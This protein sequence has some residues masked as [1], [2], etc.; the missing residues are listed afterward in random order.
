[1]VLAD[2]SHNEKYKHLMREYDYTVYYERFYS[3]FFWPR[4][5]KL[6]RHTL[7]IARAENVESLWAGEPLPK[8]VVALIVGRL[9]GIPYF[10][11]THGADVLNPIRRGGIVGEWKKT[12]LTSVLRGAMFVTVNSEYTKSI[13]KKYGIDED[14]IH[15]IYPAPQN[16]PPAPAQV[17]DTVVQKIASLKQKGK[18][19]IL[20]VSR[21]V[22]RKGIDMTME[23]MKSVIKSYPDSVYVVSGEGP[24]SDCLRLSANDSPIFEHIVFTGALSCDALKKTY[25]LC[26]IFV[27]VPREEKGLIEGFGIVYLEAGSFGKP[28]IGSRV[29]GAPEA[30][31]EY[32]GENLDD[33]TGLLVENPRNPSD[34]SEKILTLLSEEV[35]AKRL[36]ENGERHAQ[37]FTWE[38]GARDII[39]LLS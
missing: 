36:G 9:L 7:Q 17:K 18:K 1:M 20:G 34:I 29:G 12:L 26:D 8:G 11:T 19:I 25:E 22:K 16:K 33:A 10:V 5:I 24:E 3:R 15:I 27:M 28:V 31:V 14:K 21:V 23:A 39:K 13:V 37:R 6:L 2:N 30:I 38:K 32:N 35:L 4:W